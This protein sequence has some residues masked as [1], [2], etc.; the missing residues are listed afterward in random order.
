[1]AAAV[2]LPGFF[3]DFI[4]N[5]HEN[6]TF[7]MDKECGGQLPLLDILVSR[8]N[9]QFVT[10]VFRKKT[11]TGLGL[12]FF[13]HCSSIL[14]IN[15]CK[16]LLFRA[17]SLSSNWLKFHEEVA[18]LK[19]YFSANCYPS[20]IL[21]K[22]VRNFLSNIFRPKLCIP[23]VPKK[24]MYV[25]LPFTT[26]SARMK[27][28][29]STELSKLYTYVDFKFVFKNPLTIGNLFHFKDTLPESMR[30]S[31]VYIF[32]CPKCNFGT[33]VGC[34][35][36][37]LKVRIDSHRGV[38]YRTGCALTNKENSAIRS[39]TDR[40]R[41]NIQYKDF[42]ILSQAPN[43]YALPFLESLYIKQLAPKLNNQTTSIPL[44]IA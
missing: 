16:T 34:T 42:Q 26:H 2:I 38:S 30:S 28:E 37:L 43:Q 3:L 21:D 13:S 15:S 25:S 22:M 6:I 14:E 10:G 33:Y 20:H 23:S 7:S 29:L 44:H 5:F 32:T 36:R 39:H 18:F 31:L 9:D 41:H 35:K 19:K 17:Y 1:M 11:F 8:C 24:I 40:C 4:N 27:R 12:N